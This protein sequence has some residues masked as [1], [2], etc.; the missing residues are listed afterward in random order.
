MWPKTKV[1]FRFS[2]ANYSG[3][4]SCRV[5]N[6]SEYL[7]WRSVWSELCDNLYRPRISY[8]CQIRS[9]RVQ[10]FGSGVLLVVLAHPVLTVEIE[11]VRGGGR[12]KEVVEPGLY[13]SSLVGTNTA[14]QRQR[15]VLQALGFIRFS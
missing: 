1:Y 14:R 7:Y 11:W 2:I 13:H 3:T 8:K 12:A 10:Q 15:V 9:S 4:E 6:A 5:F